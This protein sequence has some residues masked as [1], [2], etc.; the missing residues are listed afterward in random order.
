MG[1]IPGLWR[2]CGS[3]LWVSFHHLPA[4]LV[5]QGGPCCLANVMP[6]YKK[7]WMEDEGTHRPASLT[8]VA[9]ESCGIA[10]G[11]KWHA[12]GNTLILAFK[13]ICPSICLLFSV[14]LDSYWSLSNWCA[15]FWLNIEIIWL[16]FWAFFPCSLLWQAIGLL[17]NDS[18]AL[19][20][21]QH[22]QGREL[23]SESSKSTD[24]TKFY[25]C[26]F[27][28]P[29]WCLNTSFMCTVCIYFLGLGAR[30]Q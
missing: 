1:S 3:A 7:G 18:S 16:N 26:N 17:F 27:F 24:T 23:S 9:G 4:V 19:M 20:N 14:A 8:L 25:K 11:V 22:Q 15:I 30:M 2:G 5:N 10:S 21:K 29:L 13:R 12:Q 6:I 28:L